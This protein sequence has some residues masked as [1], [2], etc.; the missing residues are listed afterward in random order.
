MISE[1]KKLAF[2]NAFESGQVAERDFIISRIKAQICFDAL[3]DADGRCKNHSGK[4]Y[5]LGQLIAELKLRYKVET[6]CTCDI[7]DDKECSCRGKKC[8]FCKDKEY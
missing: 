5:E 8:D 4:C 2:D 7:C 1:D 6:E 3:A